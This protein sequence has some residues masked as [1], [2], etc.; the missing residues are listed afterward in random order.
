M[1]LII[2]A[3]EE[4]SESQK[5]VPM[6]FSAKITNIHVWKPE[7]KL[8]E[9]QSIK[10]DTRLI[11]EPQIIRD[12]GLMPSHFLGYND[13][14]AKEL[15]KSDVEILAEEVPERLQMFGPFSQIGLALVLLFSDH[16][17]IIGFT[18]QNVQK[19]ITQSPGVDICHV[20]GTKTDLA[21][22]DETAEKQLITLLSD[23]KTKFSKDEDNRY[24]WLSSMCL[25]ACL[26]VF[27]WPIAQ[28]SFLRTG[29]Q[30]VQPLE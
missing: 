25:M 29:L 7:L 2:V 8:T 23:L 6:L 20:S 26:N 21:W 13:F 11:G 30:H 10:R 5:L 3:T 28:T 1:L 4:R 18:Q 15:L 12:G 19:Q 16:Q 24:M 14:Y 17:F 9:S 22:L 27:E